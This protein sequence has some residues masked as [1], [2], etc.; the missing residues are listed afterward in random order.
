MRRKRSEKEW[1]TLAAAAGYDLKELG[2]LARL[3]V[4]QLQREFRR[5]VKMSPKDWLTKQRL[6][7]AAQRIERGDDL[8]AIAAD[9]KFKQLSHFCRVFKRSYQMTASQYFHSRLADA[10]DH[11]PRADVD[12]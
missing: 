12:V 1:L 3:S 11:E 9:L 6:L 10:S 8:K 7:V 5:D 2:K 4:R